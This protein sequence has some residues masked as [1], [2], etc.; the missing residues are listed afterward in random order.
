MQIQNRLDQAQ[1]QTSKKADQ[2]HWDNGQRVQAERKRRRVEYEKELV[3]QINER[4]GSSGSPNMHI[5]KDYI[6]NIKHYKSALQDEIMKKESKVIPKTSGKKLISQ[7][8]DSLAIVGM[9]S[10]GHQTPVK[11]FVVSE[12]IS[13]SAAD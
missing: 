5:N 8:P 7:Q 3:A 12:Q 2:A 9:L 13:P 10:N 11:K 6:S 1:L 4:R